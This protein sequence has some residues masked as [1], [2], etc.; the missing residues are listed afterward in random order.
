MQPNTKPARPFEDATHVAV[1]AE[2]LDRQ[3][4]GVFAGASWNAVRALIESGK[5][6]VD[7]E[8]VRAP[9]H[10]VRAGAE[11]R[12]A[13]RAPRAR[14]PELPAD[15]F[16][17]VDAHVVVA[18]KP[19]GISTVP[20]DENETGTLAELVEAALRRK[21]GPHAPLGIVHRIDKETSGLVVFAR[22]LAAKRVLKQ[23][24]RVHS[25]RRGYWALAHGVVAPGT[26]A[27][28]LVKDRGDGRRGSTE[29][30]NLGRE[31]IT[32]VRVLEKLHGATLV[33]CRLET[34]RTHQIRIHLSESGHPLLGE[35][36][37]SKTFRGALISAPRLML[38]AFELGFEHP[39]TGAPLHFEQPMPPDMRDVLATLR[40]R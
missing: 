6:S 16:A 22:T 1:H 2:P 10:V 28:R 12:V 36:V 25:V 17:H 38:H 27:S 34:G 29:N 15:L 35:R 18:R 9:N 4:R 8:V 26:L 23:Q 5:V 20:Y 39:T 31:A 37:Y 11:I 33:E 19:A 14:G 13:M 24:F 3:L 21:G 7:G 32:H 30:Q 40:M